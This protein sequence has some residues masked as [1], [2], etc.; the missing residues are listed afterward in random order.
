MRVTMREWVVRDPAHRA[1]CFFK[2]P[3]RPLPPGSEVGC[4]APDVV[5]FVG[6]GQLLGLMGAGRYPLTPAALPFLAPASLPDGS[7]DVEPWFIAMSPIPRV[8][9]SGGAPA[10]VFSAELT[11]RVVDPASALRVV[12]DG[13][14]GSLEA[15]AGAV[16]RDAVEHLAVAAAE[17]RAPSEWA[18]REGSARVAAQV[19]ALAAPR[20]AERGVELVSLD[21]LALD[22]GSPGAQVAP[23]STEKVYEMAWDCGFCGQ[24]K[25]LGLT[26]RHCPACGAAQDVTRRYFPPDDEKVAV[27][28]HEYVG[29]DQRCGY[30]GTASGR[31]AK[32]CGGCGAPLDGATDVGLVAAPPTAPTGLPAPAK[33]RHTSKFFAIGCVA[34][35]VLALGA[36]AA[37]L[38]LNREAAL[39]VAGHEWKREVVVER[40]GPVKE[41]AWCDELPSGARGT[42]RHREQRSTKKQPDGE[43]CHTKKI[44]R[45][46][47]TYAEKEVCQPKYKETPVYD[48]KCDYTVDKWASLR[49]E[50]AAGKGVTPEP[51]WP[52]VTLAREG[53]CVGC[54]RVGKRTEKYTVTFKLPDAEGTAQCTFD[55]PAKWAAYQDGSRW[56]G[57][58]GV[59]G[60]ALRCET[61]K[62]R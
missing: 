14:A 59:L 47:G 19:L 37:F 16:V 12:L 13:A 34:L 50:R 61:L 35:L 39:E 3:S 48:D 18:G 56:T 8:R 1:E 17:G 11:L 24:R 10:T 21:S 15:W 6:A 32:H 29:T 7:L 26:H 44:D 58:V 40:F 28:D 22:A 45:G 60:G 5:A 31:A 30:C 51:H 46:D 33:Q 9:V 54:E 55:E 41:S 27:Q 20:L 23:S 38:F 49:V 36:V 43:D 57:E 53:Q 2:F 4:E 52:A 25:N 62:R 42:A